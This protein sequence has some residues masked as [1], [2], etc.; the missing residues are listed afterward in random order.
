[1]NQV[2]KSGGRLPLKKPIIEKY[3]EYGG[4]YKKCKFDNTR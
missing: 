4:I 1:M 3:R 2:K